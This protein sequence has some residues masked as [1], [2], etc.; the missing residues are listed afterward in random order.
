M[1]LVFQRIV[2]LS[3]LAVLAGTAAAASAAA[4]PPRIGDVCSIT[5]GLVAKPIWLTTADHV[6]LYAAE[7]GRGSTAVVLAPQGGG[8]LCGWL[9]YAKTL[10][11]AGNRVIAFD[12]RG[13]R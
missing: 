3:L 12:F 9:P 6:R 7:A 10:V 11:A 8:S 4:T 2:M 1:R 13:T 5:G